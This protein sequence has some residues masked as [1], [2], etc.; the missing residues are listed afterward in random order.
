ANVDANHGSNERYAN[1]GV[2][3][4][5]DWEIS[6]RVRVGAG[7]R[8]DYQSPVAEANDAQ[9]IGFDPTVI[10]PFQLPGGT[11][12]PVTN[13]PFGT[14]LVE[15]LSA[16][17]NGNSKKPF[18]GDWKDFQPRLNA[19]FKVTERVTARANYGRSYLGFTACCGGVIQTGF[20][21][22]T[23]IDTYNPQPG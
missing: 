11:I 17:V 3:I 6:R 13:L 8:W 9:V 4:Q 19:I 20:N 21:Q 16:G 5:D 15:F 14:L 10:N 23:S 12:N 22:T 18:T 2:F 7:L 1:F